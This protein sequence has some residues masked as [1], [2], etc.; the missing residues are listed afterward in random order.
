ML[1]YKNQRGKFRFRLNDYYT[2][3]SLLVLVLLCTACPKDTPQPNSRIVNSHRSKEAGPVISG[4]VAFNGERALDHVKKQLEIGPRVSGSPELAKTRDYILRA[5]K[6]FGVAAKTDEFTETTPL[7]EKKMVNITAEIPGES[8]DVV[9]IASHYDS[10]FFKDMRFVGAND[11]GTSVGTLLELARVLAASEQK[12]KATY[13][14][15]FF[16]GEEA[17]CEQWDDCHNPNPA[18]AQNPLPDNTYG[19]RHYVAKLQEKKELGR[20]RVLI[21]LDMMGAANLA[22][23][24]DPMSTRWLQD[25]VWRTAKD[26]G[27][28]KYFLE[29]PEGVGGDD[30]EPFLRAGI[31]ALD[32]IQLN[33]YPY[34]H[35]ADD[36]LDKVSAQSMKVVG[37][38]VLAS[39]PKI[40]ERVVGTTR[41]MPSPKMAKPE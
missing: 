20:V 39:L 19:S 22:L 2:A 21:L 14:L 41:A 31:D 28:E 1:Q 30:H 9:M 37:D 4:A 3:L 40:A 7:G 36:T 38:V 13:W 24:R 34:W 18:D 32:L 16:D 6:T 25:I 27:Y 29:R 35:R 15:V 17:F 10:K 8:T 33:S 11:P 5:L 23:G 12:P 26:L